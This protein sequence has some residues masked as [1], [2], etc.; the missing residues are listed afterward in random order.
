MT[1]A[2]FNRFITRLVTAYPEAEIET[3]EWWERFKDFPPQAMLDAID[4]WKDGQYGFRAPTVKDI[5]NT[6]QCCTWNPEGIMV[7]A[8]KRITEEQHA[9][10]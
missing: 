2:E 8:M 5:R 10:D 6:N 9:T 4:E 7:K 1:K 3:A